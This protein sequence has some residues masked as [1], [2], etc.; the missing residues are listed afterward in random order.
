[1]LAYLT[2]IESSSFRTLLGDSSSESAAIA[3][4]LR[5]CAGGPGDGEQAIVSSLEGMKGAPGGL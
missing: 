4:K 2:G 3:A 5:F 1:M